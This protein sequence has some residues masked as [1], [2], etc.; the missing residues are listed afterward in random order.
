MLCCLNNSSFQSMENGE[1]NGVQDDKRH[2]K[3]LNES[4]L[5]RLLQKIFSFTKK[6]QNPSLPAEA[7]AQ[8]F[9][10][11]VSLPSTPAASNTVE[12]SSLLKVSTRPEE[13]NPGQTRRSGRDTHSGPSNNGYGINE[14]TKIANE[15]SS[16]PPM[17]PGMFNDTS[18][19]KDQA[20][21]VLLFTVENGMN[22]TGSEVTGLNDRSTEAHPSL[23]D[24][25]LYD[26]CRTLVFE[27][28]AD[29]AKKKK[30]IELEEKDAQPMV[31]FL[32]K[33]LDAQDSISQQDRKRVL[34]LLS[35]LAKSAQVF[36]QCLELEGVQ[37]NMTHPIT[38][39]GFA[40][41]YKTNLES[42][43]ACVKAIR[44][45]E[46]GGNNRQKLKAQAGEIILWAHS[47]HQNVLPFCGI[48]LSTEKVPRLCMVS[49]W[50]ENGD[51]L[52]YLQKL[53]D[54][55]R[56]PL[57]HDIISGLQYL[58]KFDIVHAD[59]KAKNVLISGTHRALLADFGVSRV[60]VTI[61][62]T[63]TN[64]AA[65]TPNW[66]APE[67]FLE[68]VPTPTSKSDIWAFG[69]VC[70]EILTSMTPFDQYKSIPQLINAF[71]KGGVIPS[72]PDMENEWDEYSE[73]IWSLAKQCWNY[74]A[75]SRPTSSALQSS[76]VGLNFPDT[77]LQTPQPR[78]VKKAST[79]IDY[80]NVF[81]ILQQV[82]T[83][84]SVIEA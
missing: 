78:K 59:L 84:N 47:V 46:R 65:G 74:D 39:G 71:L 76:I 26:H 58:H 43:H 30:C 18:S 63:T 11:I 35:K 75:K 48:Y 31:D 33:L 32:A 66:M 10:N 29:P 68:D 45:Y 49:Q 50:M 55:P 52:Q 79:E 69:C 5:I 20:D 61:P 64:I 19:S 24:H 72:K 70:Y 8:S 16:P 40:D 6:P 37:C 1:K 57:L 34:H 28:A 36:P 21:N 7:T 54:T 60:A 15:T 9:R 42:E 3:T 17:T 73:G 4:C 38:E 77:R 81:D 14:A 53:P 41:I 27:V 62:T 44:L 12:H 67:L 83:Q 25:E 80:V 82:S 22:N 13:T 51:L 56:V 2:E 23:K